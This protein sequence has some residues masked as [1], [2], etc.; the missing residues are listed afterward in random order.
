[1]ADG[2]DPVLASVRFALFALWRSSAR[3]SHSSGWRAFGSIPR[4]S[5]R[6]ALSSAA[7]PTG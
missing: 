1:M 3:E 4:S 5:F 2:S 6:W 7:A